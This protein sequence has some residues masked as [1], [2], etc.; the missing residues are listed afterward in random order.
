MQIRL[1]EDW[2]KSYQFWSVRAAGLASGAVAY[3]FANPN[4]VTDALNTL[5][6]EARTWMSP[7]V[8]FAIFAVIW[9]LRVL[10]QS[11]KDDA[12]VK[13]V[14]TVAVVEPATPGDPGSD[15]PGNTG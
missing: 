15:T 2:R 7:A 5:P 9:T 4:S 12:D 11:K 8:G 10:G 6:P 1:I 14:A 3:V 13:P